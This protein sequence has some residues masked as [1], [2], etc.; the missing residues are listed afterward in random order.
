VNAVQTNE[1]PS[2]VPTNLSQ[3]AKLYGTPIAVKV[4]A[5]KMLAL[6]SATITPTGGGSAVAAQIVGLANSPQP[7][8]MRSDSAY[9]LPMITLAAGTS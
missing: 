9:V 6:T 1:S 3:N 4:R 5:G 8:L 2:P 7:A